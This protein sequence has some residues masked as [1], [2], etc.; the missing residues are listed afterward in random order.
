VSRGGH[1][2]FATSLDDLD[3]QKNGADRR[4]HRERRD[5]CGVRVPRRRLDLPFRF[6]P[7]QI[8]VSLEGVA[9]ARELTDVGRAKRLL[10]VDADL[11]QRTGMGGLERDLIVAVLSGLSKSYCKNRSEKLPAVRRSLSLV[12]GRRARCRIFGIALGSRIREG[13][14]RT[15]SD[16]ER[17]RERDSPRA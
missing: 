16:G 9:L 1:N 6:F 3:S 8:A 4:E 5:E 17:Q 15:D 12:E 7:P 11:R 14:L 2:F 13:A 10:V